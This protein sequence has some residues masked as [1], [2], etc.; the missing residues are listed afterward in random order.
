ML[1]E[2]SFVSAA[3]DGIVRDNTRDNKSRPLGSAVSA[4]GIGHTYKRSDGSVLEDVA[5]DIEAASVVALLGRSGCGKSTLLHIL[6]GYVLKHIQKL[7]IKIKK[8]F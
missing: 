1:L 7:W 3:S 6:S 5:L 8:L 2:S 4:E